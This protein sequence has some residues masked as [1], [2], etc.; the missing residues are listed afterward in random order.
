[1]QFNT[2]N[3]TLNQEIKSWSPRYAKVK[4]NN[5]QF[6]NSYS[7]R[8]RLQSAQKECDKGK[9]VDKNYIYCYIHDRKRMY[10]ISSMV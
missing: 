5:W 1:M 2:R 7:I 10:I 3:F 6:P 8:N 4:I 9:L